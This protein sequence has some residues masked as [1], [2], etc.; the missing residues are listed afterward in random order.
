MQTNEQLIRRRR[1]WLAL[2]LVTALSIVGTVAVL[3]ARDEDPLVDQRTP[4]QTPATPIARVIL[5][6]VDGAPKRA[7]GLAEAV[8][9]N[10]RYELRFIAKGLAGTGGGVTYRVYLARGKAEKTLGQIR[11]DRRGTLVG[12]SPIDPKDLTNFETLRIAR[13][14][15]TTG[16]DVLSG[17]L[18]R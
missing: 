3:A 10:G 2:M 15:G 11:P 6:P 18:P 7:R 9:R 5:R 13:Q 4:V 12:E 1:M 16:R 17:E 14:R 8:K